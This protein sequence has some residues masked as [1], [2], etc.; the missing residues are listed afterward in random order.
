M[1]PEWQ[2]SPIPRP[3]AAGPGGAPQAARSDSEPP[4]QDVLVELWQNV[5]KLVRQ[6]VTLARA[7]LESKATKLKAE[8]VA[9][10]TGAAL[11]LAS[12]LSLVA[13]IILLLSEV[14]EPW[15]AALITT[16]VTGVSG[17][18]MLKKGTPS[19]SDVTPQ[20]TLESVKKDIQTFKEA[21]K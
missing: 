15:L 12:A 3:A 2:G 13:T 9:A 14:M 19:A 16:A 20:R 10:A 1:M 7:E 18:V 8:A 6:E 4:L 5:E 17:L 21:G 11:A